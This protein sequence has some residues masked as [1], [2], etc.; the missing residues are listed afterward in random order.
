MPVY[1]WNTFSD[2][3][4]VAIAQARRRDVSMS[5]LLSAPDG[6]S[7]T[8]APRGED[9][10]KT[11]ALAANLLRTI[12]GGDMVGVYEPPVFAIFAHDALQPG[13]TRLA[14]RLHEAV[15]SHGGSQTER[16]AMT[17]SIGVATLPQDGWT[18]PELLSRAEAALAEAR[19]AGGNCTVLSSSGASSSQAATAPAGKGTAHQDISGPSP[20]EL[21]IQRRESRALAVGAVQ[22]GEAD[23]VAIVT[24]PGACAVCV[25]AARDTYKPEYLPGLPLVGCSSGAGC[26]CTYSL[27]SSAQKDAQGQFWSALA[28]KLGRRP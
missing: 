26:R 16:I 25:D 2:F 21:V 8:A 14:E 15:A 3:M 4:E 20:D 19:A 5:L 10:R 6:A 17:V 28:K 11:R 23:G 9:D 12:R 1:S 24:Q 18:F 27:P 13:A 7:L 22:R